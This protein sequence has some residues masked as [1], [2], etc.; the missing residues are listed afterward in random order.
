MSTASIHNDNRNEVEDFK[1]PERKPKETAKVEPSGPNE[2]PQLKR[3]LNETIDGTPIPFVT[4]EQAQKRKEVVE[5]TVKQ[6]RDQQVRLRIYKNA[7][8]VQYL[9]VCD[10]FRHRKA[11]VEQK[12]N[13]IRQMLDE[14][15]LEMTYMT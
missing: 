15:Y 6:L 14:L 11:V 4:K 8:E 3:R 12:S 10:E 2:P 9:K 13:E 1:T 7:L 5:A